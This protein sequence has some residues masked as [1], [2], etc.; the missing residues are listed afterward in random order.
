MQP[1]P[2]QIKSPR[3]ILQKVNNLLREE[4]LYLHSMRLKELAR[5]VNVTAAQLSQVINELEGCHFS[6]FINKYRVEEAKTLILDG[7]Q[8]LKI[9]E[10]A[11]QSGFNNKSTFNAAFKKFVGISP[12][13]F[14]Q[15]NT[16][17]IINLNL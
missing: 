3:L 2:Y 15:H 10:V 9:I 12:S 4:K 14:K 16:Q 6:D 11:Y 1:A 17:S 8:N 13:E 5:R 7:Q